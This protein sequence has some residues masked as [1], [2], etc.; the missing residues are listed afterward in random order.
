MAIYTAF[1]TNMCMTSPSTQDEG[2]T[3]RTYLVADITIFAANGV[4]VA[5]WGM[6]E[7]WAGLA[8]I[9]SADYVVPSDSLTS[10]RAKM[11]AAIRPNYA[12]AITALD[13]LRVQWLD[14]GGLLNL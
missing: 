4:Q 6:E 3:W 13:L 1:M 5:P 2:V 14:S 8:T 7:P 9:T 12:P 11:G 10:L